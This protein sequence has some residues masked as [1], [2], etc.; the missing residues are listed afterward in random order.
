[1]SIILF[2]KR[3]NISYEKL[4]HLISCINREINLQGSLI[5]TA[6]IWW[7]QDQYF[8]LRAQSTVKLKKLMVV[9]KSN[10]L[11]INQDSSKQLNASLQEKSWYACS[12]VIHQKYSCPKIYTFLLM[13]YH[14]YS[15]FIKI[16]YSALSQ[17]KKAR[18]ISYLFSFLKLLLLIYHIFHSF[19]SY[20]KL[21]WIHFR[22]GGSLRCSRHNFGWSRLF[23][24]YHN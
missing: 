7:I 13:Y 2:F 21:I 9:V 15:S 18:K 17:T 11:V 23:F 1:M 10:S 4:I 19:T 12:W 16:S 20:F 24:G 8:P 5:L 14:P 22:N 6:S 3:E